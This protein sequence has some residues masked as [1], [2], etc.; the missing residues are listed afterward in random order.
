MNLEP[1]LPHLL[2]ASGIAIGAV[3]TWLLCRNR[4]Q[5]MRKHHAE[6]YRSIRKSLAEMEAGCANLEAELRQL[7]HSEALALRR[8]AE[9]EVLS[10]AEQRG[11]AEKQQLLKE[12]E[13]RIARNFKYLSLETLRDTQREFLDYAHATFDSQ[14]GNATNELEQSRLAV[15]DL[16]RPVTAALERVESHLEGLAQ[17]RHETEPALGERTRHS[18]GTT[19]IPEPSPGLAAVS[20]AMAEEEPRVSPPGKKRIEPA[21]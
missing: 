7:R 16:V 2:T 17:A 1:W 3:L 9:L 10:Q 19:T 14:Q 13:T 6:R 5:A 18:H 4:A 12:A 20:R 8:Q 21:S 15:A 11:H